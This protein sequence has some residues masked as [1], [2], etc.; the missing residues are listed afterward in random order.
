MATIEDFLQIDM[1]VGKIVEITD[2]PEARQPAYKLVIDFGERLG[3]KYSSAQI[4][5]N[6]SVE[7]LQDRLIIGIVNFPPKQ[8]G[9]VVSEV[10]V[11]GV[12]DQN[13]NITLLAPDSDNVQVGERV[14]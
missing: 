1:R 8:I 7:E 13:G 14:H 5:D 12:T 11:L 10:L 6:Y 9:P 4:K 2:F 3:R